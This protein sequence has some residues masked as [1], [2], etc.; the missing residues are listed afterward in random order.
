VVCVSESY[1]SLTRSMTGWPGDKVV[2]IPNWVDDVA[3]DRPKLAGAEFNLGFIGMAPARKRLDRALDV[4]EW[5]RSGD[6]RYRLS[7]KTK[8]SW[9]YP[10]I[11]RRPEE[12]AHVDEVMRRIQVS[13]LLRGSVVFDGFG[14][15]VA[16]W[17]RRVG[18]VL[19]T[20]DDESFHLAPAEGMAS[21]AV[22]GI[23]DWPGADT[24]Y[25]GHWIY[26]STDELARSIAAVVEEDRWAA[27]ATL[28]KTQAR[29]AFAVADVCAAWGR[30]IAG[31]PADG[32]ADLTAQL[33]AV[34][35][36]GP[37]PTAGR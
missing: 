15:D 12:R 28:A 5:L 31:Q 25:D 19:S 14:P 35:G 13:P 37:R 18:F 22:P 8:L 30:L 23:L 9:D 2:V 27:E 4:L 26:G 24:I 11:W 7:V 1:A 36:A 32:A 34:G 16:S 21:G 33:T 10:W 29:S 17:L 20:S 6:P 3:L